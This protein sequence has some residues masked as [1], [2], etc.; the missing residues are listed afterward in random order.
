MRTLSKQEGLV[1][2]IDHCIPGMPSDLNSSVSQ[3]LAKVLLGRSGQLFNATVAL[4][5]GTENSTGDQTSMRTPAFPS[6]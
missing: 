3:D 6:G 5:V 1:R 4:S 2:A